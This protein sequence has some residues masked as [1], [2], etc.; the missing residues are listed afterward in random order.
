MQKSVKAEIHQNKWK[1]ENNYDFYKLLH[2]VLQV[3]EKF[4]LDIYK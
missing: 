3:I 1:T 4:T 2:D